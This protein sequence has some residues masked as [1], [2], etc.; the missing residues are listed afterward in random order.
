M[1]Y[2]SLYLVVIC[3]LNINT[4]GYATSCNDQQE[5]VSG[6]CCDKCQPG[7]FAEELCSEHRQTVCSPCPEGYFANTSNVLDR[8]EKCQD[9]QESSEKCTST[10][11]AK[12]S[13]RSGFLCSNDMCTKCVEN[14]CVAGQK[15]TKTS[16]NFSHVTQYTYGCESICPDDKTYFDEKDNTCKTHT[17]CRALGLVEL[18]PGNKTHDAVC[19]FPD[20]PKSEQ[21]AGD[22][23]HVILSIAIVS[24]SLSLLVFFCFTCVKNLKKLKKDTNPDRTAHSLNHADFHLSKEESGLQLIIQDEV[25]AIDSVVESI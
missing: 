24:L 7:Q 2:Q 25:K 16:R 4:F 20:V 18:F 1:L 15:L 19:W 11:D 17:Q 8:C 9:C 12:C 3:L 14:R 6:R 5:M 21:R 22:S 23:F 10:T 13:C